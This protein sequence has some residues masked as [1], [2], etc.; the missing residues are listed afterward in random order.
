MTFTD[1]TGYTIELSS[2][3]KRIISIVPSQSELVWDL[4][5]KEELIGITK[6]CIHP[7]EMFRS[8]ARVGGTK[9]LDLDK[10]RALKPDLIIG[11]KEENE[12]SQIEELRKEFP[13]WMSDIFTLDDAYGMMRG[14][15]A[16]TAK[17]NEAQQLVS[18][19][20]EQFK[21]LNAPR[22]KGKSVAYFIWYNPMMAAGNNTF[23]NYMLR[24]LDMINVFS[25]L[26]RYPE[27]DAKQL[28]AAN[29]Q[30]IFLSSE[31]FPFT[32]KYIKEFREICPNA[33][34]QLVDGELFSWYGSRLLHAPAY[35]NSL[36]F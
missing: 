15:G 35:F 36:T 30:L 22:L 29:P 19:V 8:V 32:E 20:Q 31:P 6:F 26:D 10:I 27:I 11:N 13:V 28:K 21:S 23:I 4:G 3:P 7:A 17:E 25:R 9:K 34:I 1:Q 12:K 5:L 16:L 14:I 2:P 24:R 33:K 18:K